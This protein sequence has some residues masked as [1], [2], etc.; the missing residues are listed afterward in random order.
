MPYGI[1]S[2]S[3]VLQ[4]KVAQIMEEIEGCLNSQEDILIWA[5]SKENDVFMKFFQKFWLLV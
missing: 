3:E 1:H 4:V 2:A 5:D